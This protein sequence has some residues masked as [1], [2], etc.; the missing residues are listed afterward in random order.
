MT[1]VYKVCSVSEWEEANKI[2][3]F[4]GFSNRS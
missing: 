1:L 4:F 3:F 2:N